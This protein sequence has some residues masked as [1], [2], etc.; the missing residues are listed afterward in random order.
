MKS[1]YKQL[2]TILPSKKEEIILLDEVSVKTFILN[3]IMANEINIDKEI[4]F[5]S[6]GEL[7]NT[8][9]Y[10]Q[11]YKDEIQKPISFNHLSLLLKN[12]L[13]YNIFLKIK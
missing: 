1:I 2:Q 10:F 3:E 9:E 13:L 8:E 12:N 11:K 5:C 4:H 7:K 6:Q